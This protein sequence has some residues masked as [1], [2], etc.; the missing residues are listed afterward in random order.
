[1]SRPNDDRTETER[2]A[3]GLPLAVKERLNVTGGDSGNGP[4]DAP[5]RRRA[6]THFRSDA[7]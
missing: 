2:R 4:G 5:Q 7:I 1:M 6:G 3:G